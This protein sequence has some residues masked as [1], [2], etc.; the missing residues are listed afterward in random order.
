MIKHHIENLVD[1]AIAVTGWN[2][3]RVLP[4]DCPAPSAPGIGTLCSFASSFSCLSRLCKCVRHCLGRRSPAKNRFTYERRRDPLRSWESMLASA[5]VSIL[6]SDSAAHG[7]PAAQP[8]RSFNDPPSRILPLRRFGFFSCSPPCFTRPFTF[9]LVAAIVS[10]D[11]FPT[12]ASPA[13]PET[14]AY[15]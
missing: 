2:S 14:I 8:S 13:S 1:E 10:N 3:N 7:V 5:R 6:P 4:E 11:A 12:A 9:L 15:I